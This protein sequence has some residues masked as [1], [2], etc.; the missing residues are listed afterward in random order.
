MA[1]DEL[2]LLLTVYESKEDAKEDLDAV[3]E[4]Y[5]AEALKTYD[6]AIVVKGEDGK[7]HIDKYEK[8][9]QA[10][11]LAG[12][13]VGAVLS[14]LFPPSLLAF[15]AAGAAAGGLI[16]HFWKGMSRGDVKELGEVLDVGDVALVVVAETNIEEATK[17]AIRK[18]T[19]QVAKEIKA[20]SR[21]FARDL[22]AAE[23]EWE[24]QA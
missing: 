11:A 13:T 9:T 17:K 22:E 20:E 16:G 14:I 23:K 6:A 21:E 15:G 1:D 10:G 7:V 19:R 24:K 3:H 5:K 18:G 4:L 8:P 2:F 12:A